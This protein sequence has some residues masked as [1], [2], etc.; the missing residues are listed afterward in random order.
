M[1][2]KE[3]LYKTFESYIGEVCADDEG[4]NSNDLLRR[5]V[6]FKKTNINCYLPDYAEM[7]HTKYTEIR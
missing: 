5:F 6:S 7:A 2:Q 4:K 1:H 3:I